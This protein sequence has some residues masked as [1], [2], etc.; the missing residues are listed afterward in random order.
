MTTLQNKDMATAIP[1]LYLTYKEDE[2]KFRR[3]LFGRA[4]ENQKVTAISLKA[5]TKR[6]VSRQK[7]KF[8]H[9]DLEILD[10]VIAGRR[11][12]TTYYEERGRECAGHAYWISVLECCYKELAAGLSETPANDTTEITFE[13][14]I[15]EEPEEVRTYEATRDEL[16]L[17]KGLDDIKA[18]GQWLRK[19]WKEAVEGELDFATLGHRKL[20]T[21]DIQ[22]FEFKL[23]RD[24][25]IQLYEGVY[26]SRV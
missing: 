9:S 26:P 12:V 5:A 2:E 18:M 13:K 14:L 20:Q 16:W 4:H 6:E 21:S 7:K 23:I 15:I 11:T 10:R 3:S 19:I 24:Y 22:I 1:S 8:K 17:L 25:S